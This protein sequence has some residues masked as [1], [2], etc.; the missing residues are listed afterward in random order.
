MLSCDFAIHC[1]AQET[2]PIA[3]PMKGFRVPQEQISVIPEEIRKPIH[4]PTLRW[5]VEIDD[6]VPAEDAVEGRADGPRLFQ[7]VDPP[8]GYQRV[9]RPS[10][11]DLACL[12][13]RAFQKIPVEE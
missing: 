7:Q 9:D 4:Q 12:Y 11:L 10:H 5:L 1:V 13:A 3:D 8:E 2:E 6:H